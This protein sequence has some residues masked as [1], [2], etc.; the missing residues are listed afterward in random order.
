MT[1]GD[2]LRRERARA[3]LTQVDLASRIGVSPEYV[4]RIE[5]GT[6]RP[7]RVLVD[8]W[9]A[10]TGAGHADLVLDG[11]ALFDVTFSMAEPVADP[12]VARR[13]LGHLPPDARRT[14]R[15]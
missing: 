5:H 4:C 12:F 7:S 8:R 10:V 9:A 14:W 15:R 3:G 1:I 13:V 11:P 2:R 6:R